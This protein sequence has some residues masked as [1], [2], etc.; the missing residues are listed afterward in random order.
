M[1]ILFWKATIEECP[2]CPFSGANF[3]MPLNCPSLSFINLLI[4]VSVVDSDRACAVTCATAGEPGF[5]LEMTCAQFIGADQLLNFLTVIFVGKA[6][7][8]LTLNLI[9]ATIL[10]AQAHIFKIFFIR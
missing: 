6:S 7:C 4:I 2:L 1:K 3:Q 8:T 10:I 9:W 5:P